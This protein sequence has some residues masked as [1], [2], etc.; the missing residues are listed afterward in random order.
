MLG[1]KVANDCRMGHTG[2]PKMRWLASQN[3]GLAAGSAS[4][5]NFIN[6]TAFITI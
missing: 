5:H 6:F 2:F 1:L 3:K 4:C